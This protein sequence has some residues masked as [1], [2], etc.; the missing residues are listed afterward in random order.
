MWGQIYGS[1][2]FSGKGGDGAVAISWEQP[3]RLFAPDTQY[4]IGVNATEVPL[5]TNVDTQYLIGTNT[6]DVPLSVS[7]DTE[8]LIGN[9]TVEP[10]VSMSVDTEYLIGNNTAEVPLTIQSNHTAVSERSFTTPGT[11]SWTA[12]DW[13]NSVSV[14]A[15]G[16]GASGSINGGG[17]GGGLGWKNNIAVVPGNTY[18]VVVGNAGTTD[19]WGESNDGEDSYF[20]NSSTVAG[21]GGKARIIIVAADPLGYGGGYVGDGGGYGGRSAGGGT[22]IANLFYGGGSA[23][24]YNSAGANGT[25]GSGPST[26]N[27]L[28]AG[29]LGQGST[30]DGMAYGGGAQGAAETASINVGRSGGGGAVRIIWGSEASF[31][32]N[33]G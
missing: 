7:V 8:Y 5:S 27:G 6:A 16:G 21:L 30:G 10:A 25:T 20:I 24:G 26:Y 13:V 12:P 9:N 15:V 22:F 18:T 4:L 11:Y 3:V 32:N 2:A 17:G 28:G 14:V 29:L 1:N 19:Y 23:G 31:P 33:A